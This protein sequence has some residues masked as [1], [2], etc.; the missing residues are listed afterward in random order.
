MCRV[1]G[2][3][4]VSRSARAEPVFGF[5]LSTLRCSP[6]LVLGSAPRVLSAISAASRRRAVASS[7]SAADCACCSSSR[8][9]V[10]VAVHRCRSSIRCASSAGRVRPAAPP[11]ASTVSSSLSHS[12][13][14][15]CFTCCEA[16]A[17]VPSLRPDRAAPGGS[18]VASTCISSAPRREQHSSPAAPPNAIPLVLILSAYL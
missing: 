16:L 10:I 17:A 18:S 4:R 3:C 6:A 9:L 2:R 14:S 12:C 11:P 1:C 8:R 13:S 7:A 5:S 15:S